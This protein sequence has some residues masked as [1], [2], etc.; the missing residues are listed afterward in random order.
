MAITVMDIYTNLL[1]KTNCGDCGH[2]TCFAF[3]SMVVVEKYDLNKCPYLES[4][5]KEEFREEL[6]KQHAEGKWVKKDIAADALEWARERSASMEIESLPERIGGEITEVDGEK[7]LELPYFNRKIIIRKSIITT[8]EGRE[9]NP[10]EQ[11]FIFNH[12]AQ[13][14][15]SLPSGKWISFQAI[16]NTIPKVVSMKNEVEEPLVKR[17]GGKLGELEEASESLGGVKTDE[18]GGSADAVYL[19]Q[20]FPK[21]PVLLNFWEEDQS[22]GFGAEVKLHFDETITEH[23]D[24]ESIVFLSERLRQ[25][26]CGEE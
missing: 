10:W 5:K 19:F 11:V 20:P 12:M 24:I 14:G 18:T 26:L 7:A 4:S 6:E 2:P 15:S 3:A 23:L 16:P 1:P 13:G 21:I 22:E 9:L 8:P 25:L 17:F